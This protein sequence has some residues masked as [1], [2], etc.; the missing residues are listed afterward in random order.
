MKPKMTLEDG[1]DSLAYWLAEK[2][3]DLVTKS[4][5]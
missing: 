2:K 1:T 5:Q 3:N 4:D